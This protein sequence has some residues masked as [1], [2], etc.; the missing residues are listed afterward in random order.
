MLLLMGMKMSFF[1]NMSVFVRVVQETTPGGRTLDLNL[2]GT[3]EK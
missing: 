3:D 1:L 2:V